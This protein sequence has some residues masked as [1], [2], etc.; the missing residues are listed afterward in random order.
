MRHD[1]LQAR[2]IHI[3]D[4]HFGPGHR[5]QGRVTPD[6]ST[7]SRIGIPSL[8]DSILA[9]LDGPAFTDKEWRQQLSSYPLLVAITGDLTQGG[10]DNELAEAERF[11]RSFDGRTVLGTQ[12]ALSDVAFV[13]GNHDLTW[14]APT[15]VQR[16]ALYCN[17]DRSL[18]QVATNPGE[19]AALT[20]VTCHPTRRMIVAEINSAFYVEKGKIGTFRGEVDDATLAKLRHE[21]EVIPEDQRAASLKIALVHHHPVVLP[22][23]AEAKRGYDGIANATM[24][25]SLL[26]KYGFHLVLHGHKHTPHTFSFDADSAWRTE[27]EHQLFVAAGGSA[28]VEPSELP[29][30]DPGA[31]NTYNA[32]LLKWNHRMR[33]GRVRVVT[34]GLVSHDADR[35]PLEG[36]AWHWTTLATKDRLLGGTHDLPTPSRNWRGY[37]LADDKADTARTG[38][39]KRLRHN[40]PVVEVRPSLDPDQAYEVV[41]W[42]VAH[43]PEHRV[44]PDVVEWSAGHKFDAVVSCDRSSAPTYPASFSYFGGMML[45]VRMRFGALWESATIYVRKPD[46]DGGSGVEAQ[47]QAD[48]PP[49]MAPAKPARKPSGKRTAKVAAAAPSAGKPSKGRANPKPGRGG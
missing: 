37:T 30:T 27:P 21:L 38:E 17:F 13:P 25:L 6:G 12:L 7:T 34:R 4:T 32:I 11:I 23:L 5:F 26:R 28:G 46:T 36:Q 3:S 1:L 31:T 24:L 41:A 9:D 49:A 45:L 39:Y 40:M 18:R 35:Q 44:L 48:T 14:D 16:W 29:V 2:I 47:P 20:R 22:G 33:H 10:Q 42:L 43:R 19:S 15:P 8:G